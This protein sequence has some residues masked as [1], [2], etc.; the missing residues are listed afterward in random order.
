LIFGALVLASL[1][2]GNGGT[3]EKRA[4]PLLSPIERA[5]FRYVTSYDSVTAFVSEL[6]GLSAIKIMPIVHTREG[7]AIWSVRVG[8]SSASASPK[9]RI[10]L[11]A[12]QH[13]DEPAGKEALMMFLARC[14]SGAYAERLRSVDLMIIPQ[15]KPDASDPQC[16]GNLRTSPGDDGIHAGRHP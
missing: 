4:T 7:R 1:S 8:E 15:F 14:I 12:Q 16:P 3:Q 5:D 6:K 2:V 11:M 10:L 13:G 9:L